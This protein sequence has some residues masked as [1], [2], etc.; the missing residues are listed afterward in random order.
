MSALQ[1]STARRVLPPR[2]HVLT[3]VIVGLAVAAVVVHLLRSGIEEPPKTTIHAPPPT[4]TPSPTPLLP[5]PT[6]TPTPAA[7]ASP[8]ANFP[9]TPTPTP[10]LAPIPTR[11]RVG[12]TPTP[13]VGQCL[14]YRWSMSG[15]TP[16]LN[17][18]FVQIDATNGCGR[19]LMPD[20][21]W[22]E[23]AGIK[24]GSAVHWIRANSL[25]E[26]WPGRTVRI[27]VGLQGS[28]DW[29]DEVRVVLL[30]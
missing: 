2:S 29:Y 19:K 7:E 21:I 8:I 20:D 4:P 24:D 12:P 3:I 16:T 13:T 23:V 25:E 30:R 14:S 11:R 6:P 18:I 1:S 17:Q 22:F 10:T 9:P 28:V 15:A 5:T 26:V 27:S